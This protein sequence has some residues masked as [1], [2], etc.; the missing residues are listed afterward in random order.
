MLVP[1]RCFSCNKVIGGRYEEFL[2]RRENGEEPSQVM[3]ELGI[4][5]YCCR[6]IY[7]SHIDLID[8]LLP[9]D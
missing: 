8:E 6:K 5:R 1:V 9:Y 2:E 4:D 3:D 7:V